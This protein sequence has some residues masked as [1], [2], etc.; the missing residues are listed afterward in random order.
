V[1]H[2]HHLTADLPFALALTPCLNGGTELH[3]ELEVIRADGF[4]HV[5]ALLEPDEAAALGL[6]DEA[7]ACQAIGIRFH[8]LVVR[9]GSIPSF[10]AYVAFMNALEEALNDQRGLL[11]HCRHGIGRTSLVVIGL[12]LRKG[13]SYTDAAELASEA[14][15]AILPATA[16]QRRLLMAYADQVQTR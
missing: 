3:A 15:G 6:A 1:Y 2:P 11:V 8:H 14:R 16:P 4:G 12:L 10:A 5:V 9:D 7:G 13:W